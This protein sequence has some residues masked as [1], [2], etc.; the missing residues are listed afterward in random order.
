VG[1]ESSVVT[2]TNKSPLASPLPFFLRR[3]TGS[4]R[5]AMPGMNGAELAREARA[6]RPNIPVVFVTGYADLSALSDVS[7]ECIVQ[8]PLHDEELDAKLRAALATRS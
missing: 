7:R 5:T 3:T 6:K 2:P 1:I 8:K 4:I